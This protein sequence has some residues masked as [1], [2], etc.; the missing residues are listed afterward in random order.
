[1]KANSSQGTVYLRLRGVQYA[2]HP[3]GELRWQPPQPF[4]V[5][6]LMDATNFG[7]NCLQAPWRDRRDIIGLSVPINER[8]LFLNIWAPEVSLKEAKLPVMFW[9]H[10]GSFYMGGST[11]FP[12]D[13]VMFFDPRVILVTVNY[14]LG[15]LGFLGG[16]AVARS[17]FDGSQGN[18]GIQDTREALR[19]VQRNIGALGGDPSRVTIFGES[20]GASMV[21][22]HIVSP[23]SASL[24]AGAIMQSGPIDNFTMQAAD[25]QTIEDNFHVFAHIAG[26]GQAGSDDAVLMCLRGLPDCG[27]S[28]GA[29]DLHKNALLKA[30]NDTNNGTWSM[31]LDPVELSEPPEVLAA[32][33]QVNALRGVIVGSNANEGRYMMPLTTHVPDEPYTSK[34]MFL[35]FLNETYGPGLL[36]ALESLYPAAEEA[37]SVAWWEALARLYTDSQYICPTA[38]TARWLAQSG[39]VPANKVF[40]YQLRHASAGFASVG[41]GNFRKKWCEKGPDGEPRPCNRSRAV[42]VGV[43][44]GA[45]L[46]FAFPGMRGA[47]YKLTKKTDFEFAR[48]V[49]R[50]WH[51]F[52][53]AF[54]PNEAGDL[55]NPWP[56]HLERNQTMLLEPDSSRPLAA[57]QQRVC[58]FWAAQH[59]VPYAPF[60]LVSLQTLTV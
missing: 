60:N 29:L 35:E 13:G 50:W 51:N 45:D 55:S 44:H 40:V 37:G 24:F 53:V 28:C 16:L 25:P 8:C 34:S 30:M 54:D 15:A 22:T 10:G 57:L 49:V 42:P 33:G 5:S 19:W 9:I 32:K 38:R 12:G 46:S 6:G 3:I 59:P 52:A 7:A 1:M 17:S 21:A 41:E 11:S 36:G 14:R 26:C 27:D 18:F 20:S 31:A 56:P 4:E 47:H 48:Q 2:K 23:R 39:R 58:D 43:G